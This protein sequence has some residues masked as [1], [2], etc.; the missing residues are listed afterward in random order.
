[1]AQLDIYNFPPHTKGDT[2]KAREIIFNFDASGAV[3]LMQFRN[4]TNN[5]LGFEFKTSDGSIDM[6]DASNGVILMVSKIIDVAPGTYIYD[7]QLE[8]A[9]VVTTYFKGNIQIYQDISR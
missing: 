2:F 4:S 1:M 8:Q 7:I 3:V 6:T 5:I 9:G